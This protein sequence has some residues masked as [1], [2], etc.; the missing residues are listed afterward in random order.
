[1]ERAVTAKTRSAA[2]RAEPSAPTRHP[3]TAA[4]AAAEGGPLAIHPAGA[5][6]HR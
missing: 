2:A 1:M 6:G 4:R 5:P 3:H